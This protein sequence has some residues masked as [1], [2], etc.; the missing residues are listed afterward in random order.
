[1]ASDLFWRKREKQELQDWQ[2][3][4]LRAFLT[5]RVL[6]FC[7]FHRE[8]FDKS[9]VKP[10]QLRTFADLA[11]IPTMSKV[12]IAPD[13]GN[14]E[15]WRRIVLEPTRE[16]LQQTLSLRA[17]LGMAAA[18]F[19]GKSLGDQVY[20]EFLP[21]HLTFTT[22]R[23]ALAT[24]VI[25]TQKDVEILKAA[26]RRV[27]AMSGVKR[28]HD[29]CV[30]VFPFAPHLAFWQVALAG[31]EVGFLVVSTGGGRATSSAATLKL[32]GRLKPTLLV[33]TP[34][35]VYHLVQLAL[36]DGLKLSRLR[37][38]VLGAE[39]V[40][41]SYRD[42]LKGLLAQ[43]GAKEVRVLA[44]YGMTEAK[45][46]WIQAE[47]GSRYILYPDFEIFEIVDPQTGEPVG[48][49]EPGEIVYTMIDG[50]GSVV[51]RY[52]TGD[53]VAEGLVYER[54]EAIGRVAPMLGV[55]IK[56]VS[57]IIKV[58]DTLLDLN[59]LH[60]MLQGESEIAEWQVELRKQDDDEFGLDEVWLKLALKP[61]VDG[62]AISARLNAAMHASYE[63]R[64]DRILYYSRE[65]LAKLLKLDDAPKELRIVDL[66][67]K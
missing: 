30:S 12:D 53:L 63:M 35:Y 37:T 25:Y 59:D 13:A 39:R 5:K 43:A 44:T 31:F 42:K 23:S 33:G 2:L 66:R 65:D 11:H 54:C 16:T 1:M 58:K 3:A 62:D 19:R 36:E 61:G 55:N 21:V 34:G 48:E 24:P 22:G 18:R 10:E 40:S 50:S 7:Q 67:K 57:E 20:D 38:V 9:G 4:T 60:L 27:F 51:L 64:F 8:R 49:G 32:L 56:R 6:P 29:T 52:R 46:A 41:A 15:R 45:K 26:A 14:P 47:E 28:G 17:K